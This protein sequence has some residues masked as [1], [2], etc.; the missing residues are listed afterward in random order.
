MR[1]ILNTGIKDRIVEAISLLYIMLFV[2]AA[3]SKILDHHD[4][5]IKL[6]QSPLLSVY[7][8]QVA[9]GIP[10]AELIIVLMLCFP[11]SRLTALWASFCL[12]VAF[13]A[14]IFIILNYS[15]YV[16]CSCGGILQ[17]LG[18]SEHL[19]FN[20]AFIVLALVAILLDDKKNHWLANENSKR[21]YFSLSFAAFMS[22]FAV[23]VLYVVSEEI[24]HKRNTFIR[25]FDSHARPEY[26]KYDLGLNSYYFAGIDSDTLY[27]GNVTTPL[28]VSKID[29][30][31]KSRNRFKIELDQPGLPFRD[32]HI[33][34]NRPY[35]FVTDG[36]VPSI[37]T[38]NVKNWKATK[39]KG[40]IPFFTLAEPIDSLNM[41]LR[42]TSLT[43]NRNTLAVYSLNKGKILFQNFSLLEKQADGIFDTDGMLLSN[44]KLN[45]MHYIYYYRNEFLTADKQMQ[46]IKKGRTI[47]TV[48]TAE[49]EV[50]SLSAGEKQMAKPPVIIN[51]VTAVYGNL[52]FIK[53]QRIGKFEDEKMLKDAS[54]LDVYDLN[55]GSYVSSLYVYHV[56]GN[57]MTSFKVVYNRIYAISGRFLS[58]VRLHKNITNAYSIK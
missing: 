21:L 5:V 6:G 27:L 25:R 34:V 19:I 52:L 4:F 11:R 8:Q 17:D 24:M 29:T 32:I 14:Y 12:M 54:I 51:K 49:I 31:F 10:A 13:T 23:V 7:A 30:G 3:V 56:N 45:L 58:V 28:Y 2:Y 9:I 22:I 37:F 42:L 48:S 43:K 33:R 46:M 36:T 57:E 47:D 50:A 55:D 26:N 38:G 39:D 15:T 1:L 20:I 53:S 40:A 16:P 18:W 41:A 35:F 44:N